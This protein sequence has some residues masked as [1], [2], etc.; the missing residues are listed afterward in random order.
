MSFFIQ[1]A[2]TTS[3]PEEAEQIALALVERRLVACA[4]VSGPV[5]SVYRW[6]GNLE[7]GN[8]WHCTLKT[9]ESL[10]EQVTAAIRALHSYKCP[11]IVATRIEMVSADYEA[12]LEA[13]LR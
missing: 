2:T 9:R 13:E 10:F 7:Q 4:Q 3:S 8:E 11:E 1:I 12:W 6:Q 5:T